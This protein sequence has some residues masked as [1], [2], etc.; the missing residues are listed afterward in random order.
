MSTA[1]A[2][3]HAL[4]HHVHGLVQEGQDHARGDVARVLEDLDRRSC[5]A[6]ARTRAR[7]RRSRRR[8][9]GRARP[10]PAAPWAPGARKCRP[11]T[12]SGRC[13]RAAISVTESAE[14]LVARMSSGGQTRSSS[15]KIAGLQLQVVGHGLDHDLRRLQRRAARPRCGCGP[16]SPSSPTRCAATWR[17]RGRGVSRDRAERA[18]GRRLR[19]ALVQQHVEAGR[20][21]GDGDALPHGAR[22]PRCRRCGR[23]RSRRRRRRNSR[24]E[25]AHAA[26]LLVARRPPASAGDS[27]RQLGELARP[28]RASRVRKSASGSLWAPPGG[29]GTISS[30]MPKPSRS[31]AVIFM[32]VAASSARPASRQRMEAQPS[33][34]ITE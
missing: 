8:W 9:P 16:G 29:S 11:I 18:R 34:E 32:A 26:E 31:G 3:G 14:V 15:W 4:H 20:G 12:R 2:R 6:A 30:M 19:R 17:C 5:R 13:V 27:A 10:R 25:P 7:S 24:P 28:A 22:R 1:S 21:A 23:S 33:G